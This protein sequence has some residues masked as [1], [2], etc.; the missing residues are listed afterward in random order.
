MTQ[1]ED[2][3]R[4]LD[5]WYNE[6]PGASDRPKLLA[7]LAILELCG[8][9]E[10]RIDAIVYAA[11]TEVGLEQQWIETGVIVSNHGFTYHEHL[12]RMLG[13]LIGEF[14]LVHLEEVLEQTSPGTL[15]QLKGALT[16]LWKSRGLLAHTHSAAL[17]VQQQQLNAPSWSIN[18]HR[19]IAKMLDQFENCLTIAFRRSIA[20]PSSG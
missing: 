1:I 10:H 19:V 7:K 15:E 17:V 16:T 2:I 6:L 12:R 13:K 20:R 18:Q 14:A 4:D 11:G 9:I 8:W 3:L 5:R